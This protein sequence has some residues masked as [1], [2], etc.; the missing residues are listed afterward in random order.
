L[1]LFGGHFC[2]FFA[3][4]SGYGEPPRLRY[5]PYFGVL[6]CLMSFWKPLSEGFPFKFTI[7]DI[8]SE[9]LKKFGGY[10]QTPYLCTQKTA[11]AG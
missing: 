7:L 9:L 6:F 4:F 2:A 1:Y 5:L 3:G 8:F 10:F 11:Q